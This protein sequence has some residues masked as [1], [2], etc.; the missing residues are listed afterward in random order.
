LF[1]VALVEVGKSKCEIR[2]AIAGRIKFG[3]M[4]I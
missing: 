4:S 3:A 1:L 2:N